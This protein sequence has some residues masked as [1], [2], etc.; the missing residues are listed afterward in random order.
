MGT[1]VR[2]PA[3]RAEH[4]LL[5]T[6]SAADTWKLRR[7]GWRMVG[8]AAACSYQFCLGGGLWAGTVA[9]EVEPAT[10]AWA[11]ARQVAF[12]RLRDEAL[13]GGAGGVVGVDMQVEHRHFEWQGGG[14]RL[15]GLLVGVN[16]IGTAIVRDSATDEALGRVDTIIS[17]R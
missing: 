17:L 3:D 5:S 14:W 12:D 8:I 1:A 11:K 9:S 6:L 16:L 15:A 13:A 4:P 10:A 7:K 2:D